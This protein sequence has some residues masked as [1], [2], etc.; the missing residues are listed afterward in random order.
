M[1]TTLDLDEGVLAA[2]RAL[3]RDRGISLGAAMSELAR[4]GLRSTAVRQQSGFPVF[5]HATD[6]PALTL[7]VVNEFRDGD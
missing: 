5:E 2:A 3:A 4:R 6:E 1:R 7:D